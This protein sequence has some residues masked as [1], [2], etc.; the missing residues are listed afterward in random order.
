MLDGEITD[1]LEAAALSFKSDYVDIYSSSW[2][3]DDNGKTVE[4]PGTL[5]RKALFDGVKHVSLVTA[6]FKDK[7]KMLLL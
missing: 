4:G 6:K 7:S 1:A 2:G 3:P 5:A